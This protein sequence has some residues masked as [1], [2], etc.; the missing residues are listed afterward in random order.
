MGRQEQNLNCCPTKL[1]IMQWGQ[2]PWSALGPH[3]DERK[4]FR[5]QLGFHYIAG[6][7]KFLTPEYNKQ[8]HWYGFNFA[9][10]ATCTENSN[11]EKCKFTQKR[12]L[13]LKK[14]KRV[15]GTI[16]GGFSQYSKSA[17]GWFDETG[18]LDIEYEFDKHQLGY[19]DCPRVWCGVA[20]GYYPTEYLANFEITIEG[21]GTG[22][23]IKI[24]K[25]LGMELY[26]W[27]GPPNLSYAIYVY[28]Y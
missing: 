28:E 19:H 9:V 20:G 23:G 26:V 15:E 25:Y 12:A 14:Q 2:S 24:T 22:A 1:K 11:L 10:V 18:G 6:R 8:G 4:V 21:A 16:G 13:T 27:N 7:G 3:G 17:A 5:K